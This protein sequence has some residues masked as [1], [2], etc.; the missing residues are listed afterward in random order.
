M[1][2]AATTCTEDRI[3]HALERCLHGLSLGRRSAPWSGGSGELGDVAELQV[4]GR[5]GSLCLLPRSLPWKLAP[6]NAGLR[7]DVTSVDS[8]LCPSELDLD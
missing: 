5:P 4:K 6:S 1:Q 8:F 2:P 3:Q 7:S